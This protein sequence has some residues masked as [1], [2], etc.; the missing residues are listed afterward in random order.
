MRSCCCVGRPRAQG[1]GSESE[2]E[3][4]R[5]RRAGFVGFVHEFSVE[6]KRWKFD[7]FQIIKSNS[8]RRHEFFYADRF[9]A[10]IKLGDKQCSF[11]MYQLS[12]QFSVYSCLSYRW[13][14]RF[15]FVIRT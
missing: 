7:I 13:N 1:S 9:A 12:W 11:L 5:P 3:A 14:R 8:G 15:N 2:S 4:L 10:Y 6:E